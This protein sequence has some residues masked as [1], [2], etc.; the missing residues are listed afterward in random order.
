[1]ELLV[2]LPW[3]LIPVTMLFD[4]LLNEHRRDKRWRVE[5]EKFMRENVCE[6]WPDVC[7][8]EGATEGCECDLCVRT[9]QGR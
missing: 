5:H 2:M 4:Q 6:F 3:F 8:R 9:S 1:M 7:I